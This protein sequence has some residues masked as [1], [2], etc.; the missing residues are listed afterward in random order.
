MPSHHLA[1]LQEVAATELDAKLE[2]TEHISLSVPLSLAAIT[3]FQKSSS[4]LYFPS[5]FKPNM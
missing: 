4:T 3:N 2:A 1:D 5:S